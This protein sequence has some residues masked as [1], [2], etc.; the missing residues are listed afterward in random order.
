MAN[1]ERLRLLQHRFVALTHPKKIRLDNLLS[2]AQP[3][4][5]GSG[6]AARLTA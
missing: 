6:W 3:R 1:A 5:R 4:I 2:P